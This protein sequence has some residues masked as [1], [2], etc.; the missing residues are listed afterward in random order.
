MA[1]VPLAY[2]I[3]FGTYGTRLHGD[4]RGTVDRR[5]NRPG[6]PI[7]G[8]QEAWQRVEARKLKHP[9]ILLSVP[10]R[11]HAELAVPGLCRRG[12]WR[13]IEAAC[14]VDHMHVVLSAGQEAKAIRRWLKR[15]LGEALSA[16]WPLP[17]GQ[18]WWAKSGSIKWVWNRS[19]LHS[20]VDYVA[21]Q[22]ASE[23]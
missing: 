10:Q 1:A 4:P 11:R 12:R 8:R 16:R 23:T 3:T 6:E 7:I 22:R 9:P 13:L 21:R 20:V 18:S 17:P 15:W 19:Y 2:H 14:G 5:R